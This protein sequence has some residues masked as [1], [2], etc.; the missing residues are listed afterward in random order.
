MAA[1]AAVATSG[2][3]TGVSGVSQS[4]RYRFQLKSLPHVSTDQIFDYLLPQDLVTSLVRV[5]HAHHDLCRQYWLRTTSL[6]INVIPLHTSW[7]WNNIRVN[8]LTRLTVNLISVATP[9]TTDD[10][11]YHG[12]R[13][14]RADDDD[15]T[16]VHLYGRDGNEEHINWSFNNALVELICN[17]NESLRYISFGRHHFPTILTVNV[18]TAISGC[19][20]Q[21]AELHVGEWQQYHRDK[22]GYNDALVDLATSLTAL[23]TCHYSGLPADVVQLRKY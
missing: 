11:H 22:D 13:G 2:S 16:D 1:A 8:Q 3:S 12:G 15:D 5:D 10:Q 7:L 14:G 18:I 20:H 17:N 6:Y 23:H 9:K 21:L 4:S 19:G